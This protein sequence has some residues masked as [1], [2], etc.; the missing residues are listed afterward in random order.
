MAQKAMVINLHNCV[1]CGACGIGC[2]VENNTQISNDKTTFNWA[3]FH[4]MNKGTFP[5]IKYTNYPV[6]CNH[7]SDAPCVDACPLE[8]K[9]IFKTADGLTMTNEERCIGCQS[10]IVACPYSSRD[11]K[12]DDVQY[13]IISFNE[14]DEKTHDYWGSSIPF[15]KNGSSNPKEVA[16]LTQNKPPYAN[17]Y[18]HEDYNA[19]RK[20]G[21]IE[22]CIF[23]EHR[24]RKGELPYC[25]VVCPCNARIFGDIDDP[26][27]EVSKLLAKYE[28]KTFK[29]NK[30]EFL[31]KNEKGTQPNVYYIRDKENVAT[32]IVEEKHIETQFK[33]YPNPA[34]TNLNIEVFLET[35]DFISIDLYDISGR[36]A[37]NIVNNEFTPAGNIKYNAS[38]NN[39]QSG[40]YICRVQVKNVSQAQTVIVTR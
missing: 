27:S 38:L 4:V 39:L 3:D 11:V 40:T 24:T 25:V 22:K 37:L 8:E 17:D 19:I 31:A 9:A 28:A 1:G 20:S 13:S 6:L 12:N 26:E 23:C 14:P 5:D 30:G 18:E 21:V 33:V 29:N 34:S 15:I 10:C 36:V 2:K 7:C 32:S 35:S 16:Q